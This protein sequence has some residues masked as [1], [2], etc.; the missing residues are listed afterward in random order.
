MEPGGDYPIAF[1][2][3]PRSFFIVSMERKWWLGSI[4]RVEYTFEH[5]IYVFIVHMSHLLSGCSKA[6]ADEV[7]M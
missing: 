1:Y 6:K 5:T 3:V 4:L 7:F 2:N